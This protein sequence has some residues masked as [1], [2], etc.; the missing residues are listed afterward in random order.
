MLLPISWYP[1][2]H[3]APHA[4]FNTR[5]HRIGFFTKYPFSGGCNTGHC[6]TSHRPLATA[7][8]PD[9]H[10]QNDELVAGNVVVM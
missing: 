9:L 7:R 1:D 2:L 4:V 8:K 10:T 5:S 3:R 6:N